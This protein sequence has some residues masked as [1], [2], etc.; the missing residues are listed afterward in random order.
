MAVVR[1]FV[2]KLPPSFIRACHVS[3]VQCRD[4]QTGFKHAGSF[5][6]DFAERCCAEILLLRPMKISG[7]AQYP[8][9]AI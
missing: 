9:Q 3:T 7:L 4:V 8:K 2:S 1:P 5:M 6:W